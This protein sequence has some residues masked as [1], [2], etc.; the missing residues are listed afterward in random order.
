MRLKLKRNLKNCVYNEA[1]VRKFNFLLILACL[2]LLSSIFTGCATKLPSTTLP[3]TEADEA[4]AK[5]VWDRYL[6]AFGQDPHKPFNIESTFRYVKP[7][8]ES[9]RATLRIWGNGGYPYRMDVLAGMGA[10]AAQM[11][12]DTNSLLIYMPQE[13]RLYTHTGPDKPVLG[14]SGLGVPMPFSLADL[15]SIL[16]GHYTELFGD[17][18]SAAYSTNSSALHFDLNSDKMPGYLV[19]NQ[20]GVPVSWVSKVTKGWKIYFSFGEPAKGDNTPQLE[21]MIINH[22]QGYAV[23]LWF[24]G[25]TYPDAP[26]TKKQLELNIPADTEKLPMRQIEDEES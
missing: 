18:Y 9:H 16:Q 20:D 24:K 6:A 8:G 2:L 11:R 14:L 10:V 17:S 3:Q 26:Y 5:A 22:A 19:L 12:D 13:N 4:E 15:T 7:D 23:T 21:K 25:I 1:F